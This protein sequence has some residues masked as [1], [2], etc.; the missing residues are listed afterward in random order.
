M[1][2]HLRS[3]PACI[4][5][6]AYT[7]YTACVIHVEHICTVWPLPNTANNRIKCYKTTANPSGLKYSVHRVGP[8]QPFAMC[9]IWKFVAILNVELWLWMFIH[10]YTVTH[11]AYICWTHAVRDYWLGQR[12]DKWERKCAFVC[13]CSVRTHVEALEYIDMTKSMAR[14]GFVF[15]VHQE[16]V[17]YCESE[18]E[19]LLFLPPISFRVIFY[20]H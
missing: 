17:G 16:S 20:I 11:T 2:A 10:T 9:N 18:M 5:Y 4:F 6:I 19:P 12:D 13:V 8:K 7:I 15:N 3:T 1:R 14:D